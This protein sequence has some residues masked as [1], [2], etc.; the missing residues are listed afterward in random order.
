[1][2]YRATSEMEIIY[3]I[4]SISVHCWYCTGKQ[5]KKPSTSAG[6]TAYEDCLIKEKKTSGSYQRS[7]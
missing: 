5:K 3:I 2:S 1:M 7:V 4:A 6:Q